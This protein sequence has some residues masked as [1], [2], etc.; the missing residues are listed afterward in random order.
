M[1][2][3][4]LLFNFL[5]CNNRTGQSLSTK[6]KTESKQEEVTKVTVQEIELPAPEPSVL[7]YGS[8]TIQQDYALRKAKSPSGQLSGVASGIAISRNKRVSRG[9]VKDGQDNEQ[10]IVR[11]LSS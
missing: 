4:A 6:N 3:A 7:A 11:N 9:V 5:S 1:L 2:A 10:G 8:K